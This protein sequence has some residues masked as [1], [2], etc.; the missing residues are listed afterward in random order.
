MIIRDR[1]WLG[2]AKMVSG[3]IKEHETKAARYNRLHEAYRG[4]ATIMQ[5]DMLDGLPNN[6]LVHNYPRYIVAVASGYLVGNPVNYQSEQ[7][8]TPLQEAYKAARVDSVDS[9]L[10][11]D[12]SLYGKGI[13][14]V[15]ADETGKAKASALDPRFAFVVYDN[16]VENKPM[17]GVRYYAAYDVEGKPAGYDVI[18]YD[19][20]SISYYHGDQAADAVHSPG[21]T[22]P[23]YFGRVPMVE[24]FNNDDE[25]SDFEAVLTLIDAYDKLQ[26][27]RLNDNEQLVQALLVLTGATLEA[28]PDVIDNGKLIRRGRTAGQA[29]RQDKFLQLPDQTATAQYLAKPSDGQSAE[30]L[31]QTLKA[32][33][34]KFSM[35]PDLTD[36]NFAANASGVAMK[37]KLFGLEQ[38]VMVKERWFKEA[39][40]ERL[41]LFSNYLSLKGGRV[42][43]PDSVE[44]TFKRAL[45]ANELEVSQMMSYLDG[46]VPKSMLVAQ[47]PFVTDPAKALEE[48]EAE[49]LADDR[50]QAALFEKPVIDDELL[51]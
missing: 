11:K 7:D 33:I 23:H 19:E 17:L 42:I 46:I 29:L 27:D 9:E 2:S 5:R 43:D 3:C 13:E 25:T 14:L 22:E 51:D 44:I 31:R 12:A 20:S 18:V 35:I 36:E 38:L 8:I 26:S 49:R 48:L 30:I 34:H 40:S 32:D 28:E 16:T 1:Q 4:N 21:T 37:Y 39:L 24:Y 15:Y 45:P 41:L 6:K 50:R 47:V 10:A